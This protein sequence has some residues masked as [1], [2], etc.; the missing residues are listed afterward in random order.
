MAAAVEPVV[1]PEAA[2][3]DPVTQNQLEEAF[4]AFNPFRP[5][6]LVAAQNIRAL[7]ARPTVHGI[8]GVNPSGAYEGM[9]LLQTLASWAKGRWQ[10]DADQEATDVVEE[11]ALQLLARPDFT[12]V[13]AKG[14]PGSNSF[15]VGGWA[16]LRDCTALH[17]AAVQ[18]RSRLCM[19]IAGH[20]DFVEGNATWSGF[21]QAHINDFAP[22]PLPAGDTAADIARRCGHV[23]LSEQ[24]QA[25]VTHGPTALNPRILQIEK[26]LQEPAMWLLRCRTMSGR[27]VAQLLWPHDAAPGDLPKAV[28][29]A[30]RETGSQGLEEPLAVWNLRLVGIDDLL[31]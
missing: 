22:A 2:E 26:T 25:M 24:I 1:G 5:N 31:G 14:I 15:E 23:E 11:A 13:N 12:E 9:N 16:G 4:Q 29:A 21:P 20:K 28:I 27:E 18:G 30:V 6:A 7:L 17:L 8:N 10:K 19:A 3:D